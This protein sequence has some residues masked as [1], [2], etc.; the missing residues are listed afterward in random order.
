MLS[1]EEKTKFFQR[2][3]S[4]EE[5]EA[6]RFGRLR[7]FTKT[8]FYFL[9]FSLSPVCPDEIATLSRFK[10]G[11]TKVLLCSQIEE[12]AYALCNRL[13]IDVK[14]GGGV[15][16]LL[17]ERNLLPESYLG[18]G[19]GKARKRLAKLWFS[20]GNSK[21]FLLSGGLVL[22]FSRLTPF[23]YYYLLLGVFLLLTA[24]FVRIF[25]K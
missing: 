23:Y 4:N 9:N 11:K 6:N 22:L 15:Y 19:G 24:I 8:E 20:K 25:G 14:T 12:S 21:R 13:G 17:K 1:D 2:A 10:T 3:L 16:M 5:V 7:L 18:E